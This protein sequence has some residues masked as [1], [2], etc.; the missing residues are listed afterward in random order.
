MKL[1]YV[2]INKNLLYCYCSC[3]QIQNLAICCLLSLLPKLR[4]SFSKSST[5]F[6]VWSLGQK[7]K[8]SSSLWSFR[9]NGCKFSKSDFCFFE[10]RDKLL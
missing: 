5:V 1:N 3:Y 7:D 9:F 4:S 2:N 8:N 10:G 6:Q